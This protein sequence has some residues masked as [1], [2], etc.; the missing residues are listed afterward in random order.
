MS[1]KPIKL[2]AEL[3]K[4]ATLK[5]IDPDISSVE[6]PEPDILAAF[7]L[8]EAIRNHGQSHRDADDKD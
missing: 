5:P 7:L 3:V 1:Q 4:G 2:P 6:A 8:Q